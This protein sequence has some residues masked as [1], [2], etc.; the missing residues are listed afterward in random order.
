MAFVFLEQMGVGEES[1]M[2]ATGCDPWL[3]VMSGLWTSGIL[4]VP[5]WSEPCSSGSSSCSD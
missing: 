3:K 1:L 4:N 5:S 2:S